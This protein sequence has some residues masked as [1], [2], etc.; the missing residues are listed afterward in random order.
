VE[1]KDQQQ[2]DV[3][4]DEHE[5]TMSAQPRHRMPAGHTTPHHNMVRKKTGFIGVSFLG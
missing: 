1:S 5:E 3:E 2:A 4:A